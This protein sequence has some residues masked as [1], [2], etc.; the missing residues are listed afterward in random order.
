MSEQEDRRMQDCWNTI[1]VWGEGDKR[2]PELERVIH[3]R[4]CQVYASFGRQRLDQEATV[5]YL[6]EWSDVISGDVEKISGKLQSFFVF[7]I[8]LEWLALPAGVVQDVAEITD[9]S[10]IHSLPHRKNDILLGLVG[11]RGKLEL[12]FSLGHLLGI[13]RGEKPQKITKYLAP[14]RLVVTEH[15]RQKFVF[16]VSQVHGSIK[17]SLGKLRRL[18]LDG[19]KSFDLGIIS[20]NKEIQARLLK[21]D[22][23]FDAL[24]KCVL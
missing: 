3:C 16:P 9:N 19:G 2:C 24:T 7:R 22:G 15:K 8:G 1:G 18:K 17:F 4:N 11:V 13:G 21:I 12:C 20:A 14:A 10:I 5:E 6:Q 23:V